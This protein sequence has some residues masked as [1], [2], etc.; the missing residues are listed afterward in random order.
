M[1]KNLIKEVKIGG[2]LAC[3]DHALT[4]FLIAMN[5]GLAKSIVKTLNFKRANLWM[6]KELLNEIPLGNYL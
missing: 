2:S 4:E 3:S 1:A 6:F 5:M